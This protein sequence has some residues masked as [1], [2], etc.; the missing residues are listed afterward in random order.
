[1]LEQW[2]FE[3]ANQYPV[4]TAVD[5]AATLKRRLALSQQGRI[6]ED[7]PLDSLT[8]APNELRVAAITEAL[9]LL[10]ENHVQDLPPVR[11]CVPPR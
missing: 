3:D 9:S 8:Q 7:P 6:S 2:L 10:L 5:M 1:M 11:T 4:R